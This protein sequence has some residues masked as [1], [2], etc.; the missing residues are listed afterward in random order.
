MC[1]DDDN[2][3]TPCVEKFGAGDVGGGGGGGERVGDERLSD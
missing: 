3:S 2:L 1:G